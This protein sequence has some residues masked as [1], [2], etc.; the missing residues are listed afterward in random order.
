M[1]RFFFFGFS[2]FAISMFGQTTGTIHIEKEQI[3]ERYSV[4]FSGQENGPLILRDY[5]VDKC[6]LN[7]KGLITSFQVIIE[8]RTGEWRLL[9]NQ[10]GCFSAINYQALEQLASGSNIEFINILGLNDSGNKIIFP[11]MKFVLKK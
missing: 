9:R 6:L 2:L 11:G 1:K 3:K 10:G 7:N 4:Q 8:D 5:L